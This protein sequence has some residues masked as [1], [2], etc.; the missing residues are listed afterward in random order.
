MSNNLK[1]PLCGYELQELLT[2]NGRYK[3]GYS[4]QTSTCPLYGL[5][6]PEKVWEYLIDGKK[7]QDA[8]NELKNVI[9]WKF[10]LE[11][12]GRSIDWKDVVRIILEKIVSTKQENENE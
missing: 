6:I 2:R 8:L 4:C 10:D 11:T 9:E 1:C 12:N 5:E 7:A 3:L